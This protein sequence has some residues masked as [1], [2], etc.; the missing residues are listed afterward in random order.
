MRKKLIIG[1]FMLVILANS[2]ICFAFGKPLCDQGAENTYQRISNMVNSA[3]INGEYCS[4]LKVTALGEMYIFDYNYNA[5]A[6]VPHLYRWRGPCAS[7]RVEHI[8]PPA[9]KAR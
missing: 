4:K 8:S 1:M 6:D 5:V 3:N 9:S 7:D 2:N